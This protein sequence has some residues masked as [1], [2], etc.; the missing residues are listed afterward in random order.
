MFPGGDGAVG[1]RTGPAGCSEQRAKHQ[2]TSAGRDPHPHTV[3][4]TWRRVTFAPRVCW[5]SRCSEGTCWTRLALLLV[6]FQVRA[7]TLSLRFWQYWFSALRYLVAPRLCGLLWRWKAGTTGYTRVYEKVIPA[8]ARRPHLCFCCRPPP[9]VQ[10]VLTA[11]AT[12]LGH[13][14]PTWSEVRRVSGAHDAWFA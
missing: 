12:M 2:E 4:A 14:E 5:E 3:T 13:H 9:A 11:V 10:T 8:R 1:G 6:I 7:R